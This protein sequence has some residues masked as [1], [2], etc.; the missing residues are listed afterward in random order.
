M[1]PRSA[2]SPRYGQVAATLQREIRRGGYPV[3]GS[4]PTEH[5]LCRRFGVSRF[6]VREALRHLAAQGLIV[7][8]QGSGSVVVATEP[9]RSLVQELRSVEELLQYPAETRLRVVGGH[10]VTVA[11]DLAALLR[12][13]AGEPWHCIE[14]IRLHRDR[15]PVCWSDIYVRPEYARVA[16]L[17]G[18]RRAP[19]YGLLEREF[20]L[21]AVDV[22]V[23][24][25]AGALDARKAKALGVAA[26]LPSLIIVRRYAAANGRTFE[27][28]VS[29]H[30][31]GRFNFSINLH[32][33]RQA[34]ARR[35]A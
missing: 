9:A 17:I 1:A 26:G 7:R 5:A 32:R 11:P 23:E 14:A 19:V 28:S 27:I 6:T 35:R 15:T 13:G 31:V 16:G 25:F 12:T 10:A 2:R 18:K 22:N 20:G 29:E 3:G 24:I 21:A 4:L 34:P 8:R 30:P 33:G